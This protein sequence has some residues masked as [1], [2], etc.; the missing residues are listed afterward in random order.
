MDNASKKIYGSQAAVRIV[1]VEASQY[2]LVALAS[3]NGALI[4]AGS[5]RIV[6]GILN[7]VS[8]ALKYVKLYNKATAPTV[9]TD[10]PYLTIPL[11]PGQAL[12]VPM[13]PQM[14]IF[15]TGLGIA[16]TGAAAAADTTAVA[17]GDVNLILSYL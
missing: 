3:T 10:T 7:N 15:P 12:W 17:A 4:K 11:G 5:T 9:G 14:L 8:A 6:G 1:G 16:I 13:P 2:Q